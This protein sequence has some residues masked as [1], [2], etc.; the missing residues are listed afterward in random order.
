[1][2]KCRDP[3]SSGGSAESGEEGEIRELDRRDA[4]TVLRTQETDRNSAA[5]SIA[6]LLQRVAGFS[7]QEI[8]R[9]IVELQR[10]ASCC[11]A[12][13]RGFSARSPSMRC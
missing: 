6:A 7:V 11:R 3:R 10:C 8:D 13:A 5:T 4:D 1:M 9:L 2:F 12:R